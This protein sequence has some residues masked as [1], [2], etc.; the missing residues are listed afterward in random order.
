MKA[1]LRYGSLEH[2]VVEG[3]EVGVGSGH[4]DGD[5]RGIGGTALKR[6]HNLQS[7]I[8]KH[9]HLRNSCEGGGAINSSY[10]ES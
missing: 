6:K 5:N 1:H 9:Y 8:L 10:V 3:E 7:V 4:L 2:K